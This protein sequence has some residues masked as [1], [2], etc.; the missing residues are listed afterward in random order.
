[1]TD[2]LFKPVPQWQGPTMN[3]E[4]TFEFLER[5]GRTA[6][7]GIRQWIETW[8]REYPE[9]HGEEL[10]RRLQSK[11][12]ATFMGAY[13][14]LQVFSALRLLDC[15]VEVH[16]DFTE[17]HGKV[18]F[19]VTHGEDSFYVEA[20]VCGLDQGIL[21]S[22]ANEKDAVR[23]IREAIEH[24]HSD[25]WLDAE[26]ELIN[27][28]GKTRLVGPVQEL[29]DSCSADTVCGL[30]ERHSWSRPRTSIQEGSWRLDVFLARPIAPDG[31]GQVRGPSRGGAV[32]GSSP[33][34]RSLLKKAKD[35]AE[36]KCD[37]DAFVIAINN[38]HS[39]YWWGD[40]LSAIY[41]KP[42]PTVGQDRFPRGLSRVA[43]VIVFG[44]A[45]LGNERDAPV[46]LYENPDSGAPECLRFLRQET[47]LGGLIG[48]G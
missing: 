16:P 25:V 33:M 18:D 39:E 7:I 2:S 6:A 47:S 29:L 48:L 23:K 37:T 35:W 30:E 10:R 12:F 31:K 22:S 38:C 14:E 19:G 8:F 21:R 36:K 3:D 45:T 1:M 43:G 20:T 4:T 13:F 46:Q 11:D 26:G 32:D 5:G 24:P 40:E 27:T 28:L 9:E 34:A 41:G 15:D 42:D 44:N 17:T